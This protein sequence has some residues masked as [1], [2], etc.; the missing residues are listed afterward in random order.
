MSRKI[1]R[2]MS[3]TLAAAVA[4][5][6]IGYS[7][8]NS[9][10]KT[11]SADNA[12]TKKTIEDTINESVK[13]TSTGEDKEET[14]YVLSDAGGNVKK[15]IVSD[16][17]KNKEGSKTIE[18]KSDLNNIENIKSDAAFTLGEDNTIIWEADGEDIYYQGETDK[19]LPVDVKVTYL[20]DGKELS[21][22]E[23]A[24]QS[25]KVTIRF[26]YINNEEKEIIAGGVKTKMYVPFTMISGMI[27]DSDKFSNVEINSGKVISDGDK[28]IVVG[29]AFPGMEENLNLS[30]IFDKESVK[31]LSFPKSVE[32]T[33]DVK[34]FS[35]AL[36][37]TMGSADLIS[38][39]NADNLNSLDDLKEVVQSLVSAADE[40]KSGTEQVKNGLSQLKTSF[41]TYSDGVRTLTS[42][43]GEINNGVLQ[44][45]EKVSAF[46]DGLLSVLN[47][48]DKIS[49]SL[50]GEHGAVEG[51]D[52]LAQGATQVDSG[53]GVLKDKAGDLA[54]GVGALTAGSKSV[55][56]NL[57]TAL[58]AF[59]DKSEKEP[60][61]TAGSKAVADGVAELSLQLTDMV[62]SI[63]GSIAENNAK[64][65]QI[66]AVLSA[67]RNPLTG[68][69]LSAEEIAYY[70]TALAQLQGANTALQTVLSG[71]NPE[72]MSNS[73]T[74][75]S[76]G[77]DGIAE[78]VAGL[79]AGLMRLK[80]DGTSVIA[81]GMNQ[82]NAQIPQLIDGVNE[83]K[84]GTSQ[85]VD[86]SDALSQG[87]R[88][89]YGAISTELRP[90]VDALYQGGLLLKS[91]VNQLYDGTKA[92]VL[93]GNDLM[94]AT[95]QVS[96]GIN[97][98]NDGAVRLDN[99][100]AQFKE[101]AINKVSGFVEGEL[102]EITER[103]K[104][105]ISLANDY[106]IYSMAAEGKSTSVKFIYETEGITGK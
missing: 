79:E 47:G 41:L 83:L 8:I 67:G 91:A 26:D 64:I 44:L 43:L 68:E 23:I 75:L 54:E 82:L 4:S 9:Q 5:T 25:G 35:L 27:L 24:G 87:I 29:L 32:V 93:G 2:I 34:D 51:A 99:G 90:G 94:S 89:L 50:G 98:L 28:L 36:T 53:V 88:T 72:A 86:G 38:Q 11:V 62:S 105:T 37:L 7:V 71:M 100:M 48:V 49:E 45:N 58:A 96:D 21:A 80:D 95:A 12:E 10:E 56:D 97:S 61:L 6:A 16:W 70:Q 17:L 66:E 81:A 3:V 33:A 106:T 84:A 74:A 101:E 102:T 76:D 57:N 73:L 78:G 42:G 63:N 31:E 13:F 92:A 46:P 19:K 52:R 65:Q 59:R 104:A 103:I 18:D 60:G 14:V 20:L 69:V 40:L 85:L 55:D 77:A 1:K 15:T 30:S 22:D 39:I